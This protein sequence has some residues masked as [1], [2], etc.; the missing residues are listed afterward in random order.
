LGVRAEKIIP[1]DQH[2]SG[3]PEPATAVDLHAASEAVAFTVRVPTRSRIRVQAGNSAASASTWL[4]LFVC[5]NS[6]SYC[7]AIKIGTRARPAASGAK[8]FPITAPK[9]RT[10]S[11]AFIACPG[12]GEVVSMSPVSI[13]P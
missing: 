1:E 10:G 7:S 5:H 6:P 8:A 13:A 3:V 12:V 9:A 2:D 4:L 11:M